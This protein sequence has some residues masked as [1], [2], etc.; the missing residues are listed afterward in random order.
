[1]GQHL[2]CASNWNVLADMLSGCIATRWVCAPS[3]AWQIRCC[4]RGERSSSIPP[5]EGEA[6]KKLHALTPPGES[7]ALWLRFMCL[8]MEK[9][10]LYSLDNK[11]NPI[12][13]GFA[14]T[15]RTQIWD[16]TISPWARYKK[17]RGVKWIVKENIEHELLVWQG[18][19]KIRINHSG[20]L[21]TGN[22]LLRS[23]LMES[24]QSFVMATSQLLSNT[25]E[26]TTAQGPHV[27]C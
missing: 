3:R 20:A 15:E 2:L 21:L 27:I 8:M 1:M 5:W 25:H 26:L 16:Q 19:E 11:H 4:I 24:T 12:A 9:R 18:Q 14:P 6:V 23:A 13:T 7:P 17:A 22:N 10:C